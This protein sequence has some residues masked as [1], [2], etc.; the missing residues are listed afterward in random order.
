[1]IP[2]NVSGFPEQGTFVPS[3]TDAGMQQLNSQILR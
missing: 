2:A 3:S 1:M